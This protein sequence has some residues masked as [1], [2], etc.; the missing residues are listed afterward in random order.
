MPGIR[1]EKAGHSFRYRNPRG[2]AI[3]SPSTLAR[4]RSLTIPPAW[5]DV[6]ICPSEHGHLQATGRDARGR[7]QFRYHPRWRE[8]RDETKYSHMIAFARTLPRIRRRIARDLRRSG[9]PREKI[10]AAIVRLLDASPIRVGNDEY[11]RTNKSF[12]LTTMRNRHVK[13]SGAKLQFLFRGKSSKM[14]S[15]DIKDARLAKIVRN[16]QSI[17]GQDLFQYADEDGKPQNIG[18]GDVNAYL[19]QISG[20]DFTAKDFRT[21]RGTVHAATSLKKSGH[22]DSIAQGKKN[23]VQAVRETAWAILHQFAARHTS[24]PRFLRRIS[25]V[26]LGQRSDDGIEHEPII[27]CRRMRHPFWGCFS[28]CGVQEKELPELKLLDR[29]N[30]TKLQRHSCFGYLRCNSDLMRG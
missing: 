15:V 13:V 9:L 30:A 29:K 8:V 24:T 21:W 19:R 2:K 20:G 10:L 14:H 16:C 22:F 11:A 25:T 1:R 18:S 23:I 4:I 3:H 12:G 27:R 17:P 26:R 5:T 28:E 7:K 6:W